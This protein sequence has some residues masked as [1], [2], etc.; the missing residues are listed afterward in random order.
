MIKFVLF[1]LHTAGLF[2]IFL[3]QM[4]VLAQLRDQNTVL[5]SSHI[6]ERAGVL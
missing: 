6:S 2:L 5:L 3:Q 4:F 1:M